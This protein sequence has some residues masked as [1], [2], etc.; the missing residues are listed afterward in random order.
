[1]L[2][3]LSWASSVVEQLAYTKIRASV[4]LANSREECN[5]QSL[6]NELIVPMKHMGAAQEGIARKSGW[7]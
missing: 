2:T 4:P 1:M 5:H 3:L 7:M 6:N